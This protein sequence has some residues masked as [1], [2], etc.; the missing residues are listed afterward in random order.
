MR[1]SGVEWI[2]PV[3]EEWRV[4]RIGSF[5]DHRNEKVSDKDYPPLSVTMKGVVPQLETAAKSDDGDNRKL[6]CKGDFAINSRSDRRG[7]CGISAYDGSVSLIN[8]ILT[9]RGE[10]NPGYYNWLFHT[11]LFADEFYKWGHGIVDDLWTT[12]WSEM[13]RI[14]IPVPPLSEQRAIAAYLDAKCGEVD[15]AV[16]A[17]RQAV[18]DYKALK[19]SL[20]FEAVTGKRGDV[21]LGLFEPCRGVENVETG[22]GNSDRIDRIDRIE[23][24]DVEADAET[25]LRD[26]A[27]SVLAP[28]G[29]ENPVN[30]VN[31]VKN[32]DRPMRDSGVAWIGPV[33]EG[34]RVERLKFLLRQ[35]LQYGASESGVEFS[36]ALPRYIRITDITLDGKLKEDGKLSLTDDQAEG[37]LLNDRDL[38]LARSGATVGKAFIY[39]ASYGRAAFAGYLIR[40]QINDK[41]ALPEF[42]A[43]TMQSSGYD[44]W[45]NSIAVSATIQNIG[46]DKYKEYKLPL[47]PLSEQRAI[48]EWLDAKCGAIDA[49]VAEQEALVADLERYRKS[50]IFECVTGK[51]EVA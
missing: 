17:A 50:L 47:P 41:I 19:K 6:V 18:E 2:G 27:N 29:T 25:P 11:P 43:Y 20:V 3:P 21:G 26:F 45:K 28:A 51:R 9:P 15:A 39:K 14:A 48:A 37:Y 34:W 24:E 4:D 46:A 30:P 44:D 1:D 42:V 7:S 35:P 23:E 31:P 40:V 16:A 5:Y 36:E 49:L 38:L 33:P 10:M 32:H 12:R 22:V 8:T 13:K